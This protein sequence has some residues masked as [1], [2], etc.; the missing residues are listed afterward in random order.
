MTSTIATVFLRDDQHGGD[1][2]QL[3]LV[4]E[5]LAGFVGG[6]TT[7]VE[8]AIYDFRLGDPEAASTVVDSLVAAAGRGVAVRI[9]YDAGKPAVATADDF[10]RL[11]ADP[12]PSGTGDWIAGSFTGTGVAFEPITASGQLMH[13]KYVVRDVSEPATAAVWTGSTNFTDAAWTRQENN[14]VTVPDATMA[15][16]FSTDFDQMWSSGRI[17]GSGAGGAGSTTVGDATVGWDFCPGDGVAVNAALA[18][19]IGTA[20]Q[21]LV[22]ASMVLTSHEVL[23]ALASAIDRG[24]PVSGI[25]DGGQMDPIV[26]QWRRI[27]ADAQVVVDWEKVSAVLAHKQSAPYTPDGPHDFMHLKVLVADDTVVTGSYNFSANAERN[28][29]NQIHLDDPGTVAAYVEFLDT[30]I[31]TYTG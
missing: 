29:E 13:C 9:A 26:R 10:A 30:V 12:A 21:R 17:S 31:A 20:T 1:A 16:A 22:V 18:A 5:A 11:E 14:I 27:P 6:A 15:T 24:V 25:Y 28:A 2:G 3:Q 7:S 19:R 23:A 4:A 8:I